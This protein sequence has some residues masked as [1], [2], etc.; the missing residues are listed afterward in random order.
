MPNNKCFGRKKKEKMVNF[1][2]YMNEWLQFSNYVNSMY[3]FAY[4]LQILI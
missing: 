4:Y 2:K 3:N 1:E